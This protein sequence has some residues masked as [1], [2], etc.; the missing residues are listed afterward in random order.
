M[1]LIKCNECN[2]E[3]SDMVE[4]CIHCGAPKLENSV[5]ESFNTRK[6]NPKSL[7]SKVQ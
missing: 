1:A 3:I 4:N 7:F 6:Q 5:N 2:K